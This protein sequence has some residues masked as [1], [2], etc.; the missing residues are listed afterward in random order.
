MKIVPTKKIHE[1]NTA[2]VLIICGVPPRWR[3]L[4]GVVPSRT[5]KEK[6]YTSGNKKPRKNK[7]QTRKLIL[8]RYRI[9]P[10]WPLEPK[11]QRSGC[12][13]GIKNN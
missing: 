10:I 2:F 8:L 5:S 13:C 3:R 4:R 12:E 1:D 7:L 9:E 6:M 11:M